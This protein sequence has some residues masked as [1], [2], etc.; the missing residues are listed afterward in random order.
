MAVEGFIEIG[1]VEGEAKKKKEIVKRNIPFSSTVE[2]N[3]FTQ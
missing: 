2:I 3:F 1:L